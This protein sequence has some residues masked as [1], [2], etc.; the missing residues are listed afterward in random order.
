[1]GT[2]T[3]DAIRISTGLIEQV[4]F[5]GLY[6]INGSGNFLGEYFLAPV[7][8][9][10]PVSIPIPP[11]GSIVIATRPE[12]PDGIWD[13]IN[14]VWIEPD[15]IDLPDLPPTLEERIIILEALT[16]SLNTAGP[17]VTM[18]IAVATAGVTGTS[19][20]YARAD[21]THAQNLLVSASTPVSIATAGNAG[22]AVAYARSDHTHAQN[23][24]ASAS[25]PP[26]VSATGDTG[27]AVV[28]A[29]SDH[30]HPL[31][32]SVATP[33]RVIGTAFQPSA[34]KQTLVS[35][36]V[37]ITCTATIGGNQNGKIELLS[38]A[39]NPPTTIRATAQNRTAVSLAI[40]LQA[41]NE[42]TTQLTYLVPAGHFVRLVSTQ[43][44][45]TP[46][47]AIIS[48][49]EETLG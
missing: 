15:P 10:Q 37:Q 14:L 31:A 4:A 13:F 8:F 5:S 25:A 33:T 48:Q 2:R 47:F 32:L 6:Y 16:N 34:T 20:L 28:Y 24:L 23:L 7:D 35:Y 43:T 36:S 19:A 1:M 45:G 27:T 46:A 26:S 11:I 9:Y 41:I 42:Q 39:S 12:S 18:P 30:T 40:A 22:T 21:H 49:T 3:T 29:R 38:D 44:T 17:S